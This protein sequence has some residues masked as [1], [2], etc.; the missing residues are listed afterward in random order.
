MVIVRF[1]L[2]AFK[3]K[4]IP[5]QLPPCLMA[6]GAYMDKAGYTLAA[7]NLIKNRYIFVPEF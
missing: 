3:N 1:Y 4:L 6:V 5:N 7:A 2:V